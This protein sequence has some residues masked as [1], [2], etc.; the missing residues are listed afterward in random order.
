MTYEMSVT[1]ARAELADLV[2]RVA[3]SG[4]HVVL[5]RHGKPVAGLVS[6]E[7]LEGLQARRRQ[8]PG[9]QLPAEPISSR[10]MLIAAELHSPPPAPRPGETS[11]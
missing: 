9:I 5:T 10:P 2:N 1:R 3:Y 11:M 6:A 8:E 4:E 7:E